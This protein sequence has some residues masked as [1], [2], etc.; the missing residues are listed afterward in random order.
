MLR[1]LKEFR[2]SMRSVGGF[3]SV[4][5]TTLHINGSA[6]SLQVRVI[7]HHQNVIKTSE[8]KILLIK[9]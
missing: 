2:I 5:E 8:I 6:V 3:E 4:S 7:E 9:E 1:S